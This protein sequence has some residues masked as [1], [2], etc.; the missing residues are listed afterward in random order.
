MQSI[1]ADAEPFFFAGGSTGCLLLHGFSATPQEMRFLGEHLHA[2]GYTVS[3]VRLAGH[4]T[5]LDDFA[6]TTWHDWY[7]TAQ[8][9]L[10]DLRAQTASISVVGQSMGA[11]LALCLAATFSRR[12]RR[13]AHDGR[14]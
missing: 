14:Q 6:R 9:A 8:A 12:G 5:S 1:P 11:L 7:A 13:A 4:G 3:G 10:S 2:R